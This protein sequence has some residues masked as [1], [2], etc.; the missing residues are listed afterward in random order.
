M[1]S[2]NWRTKAVPG[3]IQSEAESLRIWDL[4]VCE[5][6]TPMSNGKGWMSQSRRE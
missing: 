5:P 2:A 6:G 3:V 1:P 4:K